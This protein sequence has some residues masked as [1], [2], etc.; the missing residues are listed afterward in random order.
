MFF[1]TYIGGI[2]IKISMPKLYY[3]KRSPFGYIIN[4]DGR[5]RKTIPVPT[6]T[7]IMDRGAYRFA[8]LNRAFSSKYAS[9]IDAYIRAFR[10]AHDANVYWRNPNRAARGGNAAVLYGIGCESTGPAPHRVWVEMTPSKE[11]QFYKKTVAGE[12]VPLSLQKEFVYPLAPV[13]RHG[14]GMLEIADIAHP[15]DQHELLNPRQPH[16]DTGIFK[17]LLFWR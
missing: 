15:V 13:D 7:A 3:G 4:N 14:N 10:P 11:Y 8:V 2:V 17:K 1:T 6:N 16:P 5:I 12:K 9:H